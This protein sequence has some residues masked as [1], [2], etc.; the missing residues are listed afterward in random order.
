MP[1]VSFASLPDDAR[2]WVFGASDDLTEENAARML[3]AVDAYLDEWRAH[4]EPLV[5]ARDWRDDR[6]L[7]I[8]VDQRAAGASGCSIDALFRLLLELQSSLGATIVGSGRIYYRDD[9]GAIQ[10][11]TRPEFARL[12]AAGIVGDDS[13]V[14]DTSVV[15]SADYRE[16]FERPLAESWHRDLV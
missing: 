1:R 5:C 15:T 11:T 16:R 3:S 4:G 6:F 14:Y 9:A 2:V 7:V 8:G 13:I 12:L 10:C